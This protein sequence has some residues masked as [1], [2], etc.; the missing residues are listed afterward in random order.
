[1]SDNFPLIID[2]SPAVLEAR[3]SSLETLSRDYQRVMACCFELGAR[4]PLTAQS[5]I[6]FIQLAVASLPQLRAELDAIDSVHAD[7]LQAIQ[8]EKPALNL[9]FQLETLLK[10][11]RE[12]LEA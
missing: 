10:G 3:L 4:P 7:L 8:E 12:R 5:L 1:M 11:L 2:T 9:A 6:E